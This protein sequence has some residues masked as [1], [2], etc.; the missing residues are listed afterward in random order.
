MII[1]TNHELKK[2]YHELK[3]GDCFIGRL[4]FKNMRRR[5]FIDL[6]ERGVRIFPSALCQTLDHSKTAQALVFRQWMVP[7]TLIVSRRTDLMTAINSYHKHGIDGPVI[8]K[9]DH[10]HCGM[11]VHKW[12]SMEAVYNQASFNPGWF[13]FVAQPFLEDFRDVRIIMAG[14][15]CEA[16]TREN[17]NNFR[18]NLSA[19]G[20]S[21]PYD[22]DDV[23]I[24]L[25]R[26]V[27]ERG[28]F[29]YAH[30]DILVTTDGHNYLSE[31]ALNGGMKGARIEREELDA[32]K[33]DILEKAAAGAYA[34]G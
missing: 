23:Q 18:K 13:P 25:C 5:I 11:G 21:R 14:G 32:I 4:T 22:L 24:S 7:F 26:Q 6:M 12:D 3:A 30:V 31:I 20:T 34:E 2:R 33:Q 27:M 19:G 17:Q 28:R 29:P 15:H 8:T 10:M 9:E 1:R 16:Y